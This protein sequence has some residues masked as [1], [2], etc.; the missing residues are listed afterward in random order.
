MARKNNT[1]K[2][3]DS[4]GRILRTGESQRKDGTYDHHGHPAAREKEGSKIGLSMQA[5]PCTAYFIGFDI[6]YIRKKEI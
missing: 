3:R 2:R 1:T 4:R 5:V 6:L